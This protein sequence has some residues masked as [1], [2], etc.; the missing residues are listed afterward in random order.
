MYPAVVAWLHSGPLPW[1]GYL[2]PRPGLL[3]AA[4]VLVCGALFARRAAQ[5]GFTTEI[6]LEAILAGTLG[7]LVGT[8]LFY[9]V[10]RTRFWELS[11]RELV[12]ASRGTA[13]WGVFLGVTLGLSAYAMWRKIRP[14][15][16]IDIGTSVAGVAET[17]GRV[18]C[19]ITGDDFGKVTDSAWGIRYPKGSLAWTAHLR[20]G[21]VQPADEWSLPV[22]PNT[23]LLGATAF[24]VFL[25][26]S[27][28]WRGHRQQVGRTTALFCVLYGVERFWVEFLRDPDAGGASGLL[29]HSQYMCLALVCAGVTLW[30][31]LARRASGEPAPA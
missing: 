29:S 5:S 6:A 23:L 18:N 15:Q 2:V 11:P 16:L 19:W 31:W 12:D 1:L 7:A 20:R 21:L 25:V 8:R 17:I 13:S 22:H 27:W 9:L 26:T 4:V 30:W 10:T 28:Y 3:Y 14:L 24:V